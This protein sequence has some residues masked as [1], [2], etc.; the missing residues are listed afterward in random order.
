MGAGAMSLNPFCGV[1][2]RGGFELGRFGGGE[3]L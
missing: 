2:G 3:D 1:L